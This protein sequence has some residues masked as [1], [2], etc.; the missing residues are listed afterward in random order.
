MA[1]SNAIRIEDAWKNNLGAFSL[2]HD[3]LRPYEYIDFY[4]MYVVVGTFFGITA[5]KFQHSMTCCSSE[6]LTL[7]L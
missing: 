6:I 4:E 5:A 2:K 7:S 1:L 3:N